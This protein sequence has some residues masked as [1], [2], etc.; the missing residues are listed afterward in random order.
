MRHIKI[1]C[2]TCNGKGYIICPR[3]DGTGFVGGNP[4]GEVCC[5]GWDDCPT[6]EGEGEVEDEEY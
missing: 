6:C 4:M 3:C 2:P 5:G 1:T